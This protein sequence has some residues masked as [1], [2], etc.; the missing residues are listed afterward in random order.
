MDIVKDALGRREMT[1]E[2]VWQ[3]EKYR[4]EWI[5]LI[6]L[7]CW[8]LIEP[9][10]LDF[11]ELSD[12]SPALW[13]ITYRPLGCFRTGRPRPGLSPTDRLDAVTN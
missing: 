7:L 2:A 11:C 1:A 3:F 8:S 6:F 10:L 13:L 9:F 5:T 12:R 4:K